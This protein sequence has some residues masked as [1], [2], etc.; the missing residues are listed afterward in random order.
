[1]LRKGYTASVEHT[2]KQPRADVWIRIVLA[3]LIVGLLVLLGLLYREYRQLQEDDVIVTMHRDLRTDL[4]HHAPGDM[5][6]P[7]LIQSWMTFSYVADVYGVS[8]TTLQSALNID[9]PRYPRLGI[10]EYAEDHK[11][12]QS[13]FLLQ[14]QNAVAAALAQKAAP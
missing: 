11:L 7:S 1:M 12:N 14:V 10:G 3:L 9:D 4:S 5:T 2:D 13:N 6:D 8:T